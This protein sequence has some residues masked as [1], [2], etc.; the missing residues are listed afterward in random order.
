MRQLLT[1]GATFMIVT[2]VGS[3]VLVVIRT[4]VIRQYGLEAAGLYQAAYSISALNASL[5][6]S[7]MATDYFPRLSAV[8]EDRSKTVGMINQQLHSALLLAS[9]ILIGM[10]A[11][12][13]LLLRIL[14]SGA[15]TAGAE[16]LRW[17]LT[18]ELFKLP[19][20]ALA[21]LLLARADK[22]LYLFVEGTFVVAYGV[23]TLLLLPVAG[24]AGAGF[25]YGAAYLIYS[26]LLIAVCARRHGAKLTVQNQLHLGLVGAILIALSLLGGFAP[27]ISALAGTVI[28]AGF[29]AYT[30]RHLYEIRKPVS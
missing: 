28:A 1:L 8:Q 14:Y 4:L 21:F 20:W 7:A 18:G 13:P 2:A 9:P 26:L 23:G 16:L 10:L 11:L 15:F 17:Q 24:I 12:A 30:L 29:G 22:S 25:A 5:V 19:G 27:R 3:A 6:L